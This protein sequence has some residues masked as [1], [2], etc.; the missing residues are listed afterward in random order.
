MFKAYVVIKNI[1]QISNNVYNNDVSHILKHFFTA[2]YSHISIT[3]MSFILKRNQL[4]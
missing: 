1:V 4:H 2:P 3:S